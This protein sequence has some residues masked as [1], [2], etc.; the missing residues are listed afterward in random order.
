MKDGSRKVV[1]ITEVVGM[2]GDTITLQDI[3]TYKV[4]GIDS[5]GRMKGNFSS[6]GIRP[7]FLDK[8]TS[9]GIIVRDDWFVN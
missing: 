3:F 5:N 1:N 9:S 2:E 7:N 4:E 8:L 6:T